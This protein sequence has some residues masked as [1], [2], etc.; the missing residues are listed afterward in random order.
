MSIF[1]FKILYKDLIRSYKNLL[2]KI[3]KEFGTY[4]GVILQKISCKIL[5][6]LLYK[7]FLTR[8]FKKYHVRLIKNLKHYPGVILLQYY[9]RSCKYFAR[10]SYE[11]NRTLGTYPSV[12]LPK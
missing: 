8:S 6:I 10:S 11:I 4:P 9:A 7:I 12:I 2:R 3:T 5:T 1:S